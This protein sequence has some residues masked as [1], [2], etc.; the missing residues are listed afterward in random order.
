MKHVATWDYVIL[1]ASNEE[2]AKGYR[3][4]I[5]KRLAKGVL[6]SSTH[7][8]VVPDPNG[9]RC[10][11]GGATLAVLRYIAEQEN[12]KDLSHLKILCIHSGGDSKRVPQYSACGENFF[13]CSANTS[14][15]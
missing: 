11:S 3:L 15:W 14:G 5:Y 1:T 2:Q 10:G 6:S 4:Q 9:K 13:S 7:Y 12:T 8:A